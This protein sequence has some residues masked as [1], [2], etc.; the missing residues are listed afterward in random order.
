MLGL[1][2][3]GSHRRRPVCEDRETD[4]CSEVHKSIL[5]IVCVIHVSLC[6]SSVFQLH[7]QH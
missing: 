1:T 2:V 7:I 5:S 3:I 4:K 6:L